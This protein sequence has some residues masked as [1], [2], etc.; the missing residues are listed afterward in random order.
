MKKVSDMQIILALEGNPSVSDTAKELKIS[1]PA[2]Y[3]RMQ[4]ESFKAAKR[5][6]DRKIYESLSAKLQISAK[7]AINALN[8][9]LDDKEASPGVRCRAAATLLENALKY[10]DS[11]D[12]S[13]RLERLEALTE[14]D[15]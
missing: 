12:F 4:K 8:S 11:V 2:L 3:D 1:R 15:K 9:I 7:K 13:E 5:E 10:R 6:Y 14:S